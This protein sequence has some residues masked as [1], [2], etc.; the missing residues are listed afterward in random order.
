LQNH[1]QI[2]LAKARSVHTQKHKFNK[3]HP[4]MKKTP[5]FVCTTFI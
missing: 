4:M 1:A 2:M 5:K 3:A